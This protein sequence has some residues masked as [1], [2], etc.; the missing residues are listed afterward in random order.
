MRNGYRKKVLM[1]NTNTDIYTHTHTHELGIIQQLYKVTADFVVK[2]SKFRKQTKQT[3][4]KLPNLFP[5]IV[6]CAKKNIPV[7]VLVP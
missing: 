2:F 3:K 5:I 6:S 4:G 1:T 7:L